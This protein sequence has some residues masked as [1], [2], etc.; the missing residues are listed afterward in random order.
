MLLASDGQRAGREGFQ[1]LQ[2]HPQV[3]REA[4]ARRTPPPRRNPARAVA[5]FIPY[6]ILL[7]F[8]H[9]TFILC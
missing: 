2:L 6:N 7:L 9:T 4:L 3:C 8:S 1:A 5:T